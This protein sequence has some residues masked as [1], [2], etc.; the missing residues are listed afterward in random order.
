VIDSTAIPLDTVIK[1]ILR[2]LSSFPAA[3][4]ASRLASSA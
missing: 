2:S 1:V 3:L 4:K